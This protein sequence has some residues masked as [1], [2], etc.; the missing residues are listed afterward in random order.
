MTTTAVW[1]SKQFPTIYDGG[2][3]TAVIVD[4]ASFEQIEVVMDNL[5]NRR[6][7]PEDRLI[8]QSVTLQRLAEKVLA[9]AEPLNNWE[10]ALDEF[11][12]RSLS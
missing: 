9:T 10:K 6:V 7:E 3:P 11:L 4:I 1:N 8:A 5:L 2:K 12:L